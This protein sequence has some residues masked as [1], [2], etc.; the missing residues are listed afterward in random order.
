[1]EKYTELNCAFSLK[2]HTLDEIVDTLLFMT[3]QYEAAP[4]H[5]PPHPLFGATRW[6]DISASR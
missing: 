2:R 5:F 6:R 3:G 1:M 4:E